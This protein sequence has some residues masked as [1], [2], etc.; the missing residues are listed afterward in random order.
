MGVIVETIKEGDGKNPPAGSKV[1][2]HYV[3]TLTD[4]TKFDS[5]RD[6]GSP[7]SFTLGVGQVIKGWDEG[8]AQMSKG[9]VA[10]LTCSPDYAYGERGVGR[11]IPPNAT[12]TFEVEL[13]DFQV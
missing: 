3:G 12:L 13:I 6:R 10:K 1:E 5:S 11:V 4:G 9:Q 8:V 7:F 2:V